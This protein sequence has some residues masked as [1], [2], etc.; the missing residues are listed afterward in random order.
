MHNNLTMIII[1]NG[2]FKNFE[3]I[4]FIAKYTKIFFIG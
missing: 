3:Y 4:I 2:K 1:R